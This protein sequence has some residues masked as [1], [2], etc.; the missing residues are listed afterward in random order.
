MPTMREAKQN[1]PTAKTR[2]MCRDKDGKPPVFQAGENVFYHE[3]RQD[4][5][6]GRLVCVL[7]AAVL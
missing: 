5:V 3:A 4:D 2:I 7:C 6:T 1:E